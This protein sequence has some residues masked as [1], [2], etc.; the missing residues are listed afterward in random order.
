MRR[1]YEGTTVVVE[2]EGGRVRD[3]K[4]RPSPTGKDTHGMPLN[5]NVVYRDIP[6]KAPGEGEDWFTPGAS[7]PRGTSGERT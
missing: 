3:V 4:L 2:V 5:V 7:V 6:G 1:N